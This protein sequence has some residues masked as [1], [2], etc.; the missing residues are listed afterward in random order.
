MTIHRICQ[1]ISYTNPN[2]HY[3]LRDTSKRDFAKKDKIADYFD[4]EESLIE[5]K[6]ALKNNWW[7]SLEIDIP[8]HYNI[9]KR[10]VRQINYGEKFAEIGKYEYPIRKKNT[11]RNVNNF[12]K[13]D[14]LDI[15][16]LL[17]NTDLTMIEIG[18]KYN[19]HRQTV[20]N[21]NKG[22][23]FP[24]KDYIYPARDTKK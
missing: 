18:R 4:S 14:V 13:Q 21:I 10:I 17:K 16:D 9:P 15:L 23:S 19:I 20:S 12:T 3:P 1:G 11:V 8:K 6:E 22:I 7:E 5:L 2:L 24:I